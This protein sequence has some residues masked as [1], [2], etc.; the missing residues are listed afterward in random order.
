MQTHAPDFKQ[1]EVPQTRF[2]KASKRIPD[3]VQFVVHVIEVRAFDQDAI[4][5]TSAALWDLYR[6]WC[7]KSNIRLGDMTCA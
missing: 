1:S 7:E 5:I 4:T 2:H 3:I 6:D